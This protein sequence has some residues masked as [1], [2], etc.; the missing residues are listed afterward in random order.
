EELEVLA[1]REAAVVRGPLG[2]PPGP[3]APVP[4]DRAFAGLQRAGEDRQQGRLPGAVRADEGKRLARSNVE[5]GRVKRD[6]VAE[7]TGPPPG[8]E[9]RNRTHPRCD[10]RVGSASSGSGT[11]ETGGCGCSISTSTGTGPPS[12]QGL[13]PM[14]S[15]K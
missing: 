1:R 12:A 3:D 6:V 10:R 11:G 8:G 7:P 4:F 14:R 13:G 5:V 2:H 15:E 9:E